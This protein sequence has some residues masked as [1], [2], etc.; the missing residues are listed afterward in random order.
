MVIVVCGRYATAQHDFPFEKYRVTREFGGK[1]APPVVSEGEAHR[2]RTVLREGAKEGPNFA[3]HYTLVVWGCGSSCASFAIVDAITGK[4]YWPPFSGFTWTDGNGPFTEE[5]LHYRRHSTLLV[6]Q[7]C[8]E[9]KD[10]ATRHYNWNGTSLV[11]LETKPLER[12]PE[13]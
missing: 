3:G 10:C 6:V 1:P 2:F 8:P 4:V 7:G 11:L 12:L 13:N 5:G 9:E